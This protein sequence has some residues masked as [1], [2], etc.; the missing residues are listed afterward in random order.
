MTQFYRHDMITKRNLLGSE[1]A[2]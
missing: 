2:T 1:I